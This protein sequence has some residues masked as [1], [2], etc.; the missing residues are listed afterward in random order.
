MLEQQLAKTLAHL[1]NLA[2]QPGWKAYVWHRAK[3]IAETSPGFDEEFLH[4]IRTQNGPKSKS[5]SG[6][7]T[8][9]RGNGK[10]DTPAI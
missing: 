6:S 7:T 8:T 4:A 9:T 3:E 1:L 5:D 10:S 2:T